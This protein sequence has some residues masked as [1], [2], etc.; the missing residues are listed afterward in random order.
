MT[1][2][3]LAQLLPKDL[4]NQQLEANV[5]PPHWTN[6]TP[7]GNYNLV[8]IG[9]GTAGLVTAAGAAGLGA[10]VALIELELMGGDCLNVGCVPS[11]GVIRAARVAATVRDAKPFGVEFPEDEIGFDFGKAMERM[12]RLR[13]KISPNDSA[14]RFEEF[15][16][17]VF[18]G[19]GSF[20][21]D[22]TITVTTTNGSKTNLK[23]KK[24]VIASGARASAPPIPGLDTIDYLTNETLFSLTELPKRFGI[25]GSGPIG[26]EMAQSFARFGSEVFLFERSD[27]ILPREDS[28]AAAIVQKQFEHDGVKLMFNSKDMQLGPTEDGK[29][30]VSVAQNGQTSDTIVDQLL[31]AVGRAPNIDGLNLEAVKVNYNQAG[32]EVNDN[33]QTTNPRIYAAGD[34]CSKYKFTHAADFQARIVIQNA[35]FALGPFGRKKASDLIIPWATY[36]SP[37]I[38]HVGAYEAEAK[39]SGIEIDTY[40]QHFSDVDRAILEGQDEGFVKLHT[41]RGTDEIVGATIVAENAG[42]LI[43]EITVAMTNGLGLSKIG[44]TIHPY[45]TQA[46]AIRKLGDQYSRTRLTPFIKSLFRKWLSWTR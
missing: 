8:V 37:E 26:S 9:A 27:H 2:H 1:E 3:E 33:L 30:R 5:H 22:H 36:T 17:D 24:A 12:R 19:Q 42:D 43:S 28:D 39:E 4:H 14:K 46:E 23:F 7:S 41:R 40:I 11:K 44:S 6:P 25:V 15:G 10:K 32:V 34:V 35:L 29:I 20:V 16:I 13:A 21:D 18:F 38:A 45:P 31:V